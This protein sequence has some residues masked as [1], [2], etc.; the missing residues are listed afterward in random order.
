MPIE[1]RCSQCGKLLRTEDETIGRQAQCP[2]CGALTQVPS[3]GQPTGSPPPLAP[4]H[5]SDP[6]A[7]GN[8]FAAGP[9]W[10]GTGGTETPYPPHGPQVYF[11][12]PAQ[13]VSAP[14]TA[15]IVTGILGIFFQ[16]IGILFCLA[17]MGIGAGVARGPEKIPIL[18][19]T[20]VN[21]IFG[22][23]GLAVCAVVILG[24]MKM[25]NLEHHTLAMASA[26]LAVIPCTSPCCL[27]G[28]PFGIW[29][30]IVLND[31]SVKA[32]FRS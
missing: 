28:I 32:A 17:Q 1:F 10:S 23:I 27:L 29:A 16:I 20:G 18:F 25:K 24:A 8:P 5:A 26:I 22:V 30:L 21:L 13:R 3:S 31:S 14:A 6:G 11:V 2:E 15:L 19:G 4:L 12:P 7:S 9:D